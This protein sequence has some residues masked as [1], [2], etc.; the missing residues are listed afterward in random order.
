M[1]L[2]CVTLSP[3]LGNSEEHTIFVLNLKNYL[4]GCAGIFSCSMWTQL[5]HVGSRS[6]TTDRTWFPS[7]EVQCL[8]HWTTREVPQTSDG[9]CLLICW[10]SHIWIIQKPASSN[11]TWPSFSNFLSIS[12]L[13]E[14]LLRRGRKKSSS[15]S[16]LQ[17]G[18]WS[19]A[20]LLQ[21]TPFNTCS[22]LMQCYQLSGFISEGNI[23]L[24]S[25]NTGS[26]ILTSWA[27]ICV[28]A[29]L[30]NQPW[31]VVGP[32]TIRTVSASGQSRRHN[33]SF[34]R[35]GGKRGWTEGKNGKRNGQYIKMTNC[36]HILF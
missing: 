12:L 11:T 7:L 8:S 25:G 19:R 24:T 36:R 28:P 34:Q 1:A 26:S 33:V 6:L 9:N 17:L 4:F 20:G 3:P 15:S 13:I 14:L 31:G 27:F 23:Q 18:K 29:R 5:W 35:N 32:Q 2:H 30:K 22:V 16:T 10:P 21:G